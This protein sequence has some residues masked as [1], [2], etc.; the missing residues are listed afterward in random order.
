[1]SDVVAIV[2]TVVAVAAGGVAVLATWLRSRQDGDTEG[3]ASIEFKVKDEKGNLEY[4]SF[5]VSGSDARRLL[6]MIGTVGQESTEYP[7]RPTPITPSVKR[8][9]RV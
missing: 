8:A 3:P 9:R 1:M 4:R 7:Q 2:S 6:T 5:H